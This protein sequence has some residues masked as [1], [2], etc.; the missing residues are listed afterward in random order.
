MLRLK[1]LAA[2]S[3]HEAIF[4]ERY[5]KLFSWLLHL[6]DGNREL[7]E[8]LVQD[9]FIQFTFRRPDLS[10]I[11]NLDNYLYG[12]V[13]NLHLS[14]V[15]RSTNNR[16]Q[17][18]EVLDYDSSELGLRMTDPRDQIRVQDELRRICHYAC[19]RKQSSWAGS[20]LILRFFHGYYPSEI[21]KV[22]RNSR[23]S[24]DVLLKRARNEIKHYLQSARPEALLRDSSTFPLGNTGFARATDDFLIELREMIL[25]F[26]GGACITRKRIERLYLSGK[27]EEMSR[28]EL[29]HLVSC[30]SCL[31]IV[32]KHLGLVKLADRY[33]TETLRRDSGKK[34]DG[35]GGN[36]GGGSPTGDL[37][38][39]RR[40]AKAVFEHR[41]QEL[42]IAVNGYVL[43]SQKINSK[44]SE[45]TL[46]VNLSESIGFV[47]VFSEQ[48]LRL[49]FSCIEPPPAG[50]HELTEQIEL[51]DGRRLELTLRFRI[52]W[53]SLH[54]AY[55]DPTFD[56]MDVSAVEGFEQDPA[57]T[58]PLDE[59][60][61]E[62]ASPPESSHSRFSH[63]R[64]PTLP[65]WNFWLRPEAITA[66]VALVILTALIFVN[67][68]SPPPSA[69][70][71]L[72]Q[73][74]MNEQAQFARTDQILHRTILLDEKA[75][76]GE[77]L[78]HRRIEVWHSA[79]NGITARRIYDGGNQLIAGD[80]RRADGVETLYAHGARPQ[81][82]L[83]P[84][85]RP[86]FTVSFENAWQIDLTA[87]DFSTL[88]REATLELDESGKTYLVRYRSGTG[89]GLVHGSLVLS[90]PDLRAIEQ[91][92]V[93]RHAGQERTYSYREANY[94]SHAKSAIA[95]K[96][97]EPEADL[98]GKDSL[99]RPRGAA[100]KLVAPPR[101][102]LSA[103]LAV[104][105]PAL[106]VEA[107]RLLHLAGAD[108]GEQVTLT[109]LPDGRLNVEA[110][111]ETDHRKLQIL[112]ALSSLKDNPAVRIDV[113]T[114]A[115]ALRR[116]PQIKESTAAI[117][118]SDLTAV[119][120]TIPVEAELRAFF[121]N[122]GFAN[123][124]LGAQVR[125]FSTRII[126]RSRDALNHAWALR[127]LGERFSPEQLRTLDTE[128]KTKW[129]GLVRTHAS[130]LQQATRNLRQ[131]LAPIFTG[132]NAAEY[133][134]KDDEDLV[135]NI[136][137]LFALCFGNDQA[138]NAAFAI[139]PDTDKA[140]AV[141]S[142]KFWRSLREAESLAGKIVNSQ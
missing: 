79:E 106:E 133:T 40:R 11:E 121:S 128:T 68:S 29:A 30:E 120:N 94:E 4:V 23:Q 92:L 67:R 131:E 72:R 47:E 109:H 113:S 74:V 37:G 122:R 1:R 19:A 102:P 135:R 15:R 22:L 44:L 95:P 64:W 20:V 80:W 58:Q 88:A 36:S 25:G 93:I 26:N 16:L 139:S 142:S 9:A 125:Q 71:I 42:H 61:P 35:N 91:Q 140:E 98:L 60:E 50:P 34:D 17:P 137:R 21:S 136:E 32:N 53:P 38:R 63:S 51:S 54:V 132:D 8:D 73:S 31:D 108:M 12:L 105:T 7:A 18:L 118:V 45:Q 103:S 119:T 2:R 43:G 46:E 39:T 33:P 111:V 141:K 86:T 127:R 28:P 57:G 97:F 76:S 14:Q 130:A 110:L 75:P 6:T 99:T 24:V 59:S 116:K 126:V 89:E 3:N 117:D 84:D 52:P 56:E 65:G 114:V 124:K 85:K 27:T 123:D 138:I 49:L 10:S 107:L 82:Q 69:Q 78:S 134:L 70:Q 87:Q 77:V 100:E 129:L 115:E 104:A 55:I 81:I 112:S 83:R 41:P 90:R 48:Q 62:T 96:V 101:P 66:M 5:Q 13:R